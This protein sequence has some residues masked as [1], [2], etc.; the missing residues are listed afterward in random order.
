MLDYHVPWR[1]IANLNSPKL[2]PYILD[3]I[4]I[5]NPNATTQG[6]FGN[7]AADHYHTYNLDENLNGYTSTVEYDGQVSVPNHVHEIKNG[8][9]MQAQHFIG[10]HIGSTLWSE[11]PQYRNTAH[12]HNMSFADNSF[13]KVSDVYDVYFYRTSYIDIE[14]LKYYLIEAREILFHLLY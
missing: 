5:V 1:L 3:R 8:Q 11:D 7:A 6:T 4:Q 12:I 2:Y 14:T 13:L 10:G 9:L